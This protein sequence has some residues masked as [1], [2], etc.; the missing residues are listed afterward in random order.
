MAY[1]I[2]LVDWAMLAVLL[3]SLVLGAVR[4]LVQE[5]VSL[6]GWV[7]AFVL[8]RYWGASLGEVL[9]M[10]N[11]SAPLRLAAGFAVVFVL[12]VF[13]AALLGWLARR[14]LVAVGMSAADRALGALFG[15]IRGLLLLLAL[16]LVVGMTPLRAAPAWQVSVGVAWLSVVLKG[17]K[18]VLPE[19][20]GRYLSACVESSALPATRPSIS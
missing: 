13:T 15:G 12:T 9:P 17:L 10:G 3:V 4:G 1:G 6:L 19:Q 11:A 2:A 18:P 14:L 7:L 16:V 8:A 20:F 5:L